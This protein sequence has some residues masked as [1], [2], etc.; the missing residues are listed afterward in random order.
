MKHCNYLN[1]FLCGV[2][3]FSALPATASVIINEVD[4][5]QPGADIAEFIELYNNGDSAISLDNYYIELINGFNNSVYNTISLTGYS[6]DSAGY[7]VVCN[8]ASLVTNCNYDTTQNSSWIQNGTPDAVALFDNI[9]LLD[10]LAY[11]GE[12]APYTENSPPLDEDNN[13]FI[14]SLS[15][16]PN[17]IDTNNNAL[18]FG[19]GCITPGSANIA[20]SGDCSTPSAVPLPA[21][22][23]LFG[24]GLVGLLG[25]ARRKNS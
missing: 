24:S 13:T 6:I 5:D 21:A 9:G 20:G 19:L 18:D 16:L 12:I 2:T 10:S 22:A 25:V 17:G 4:Y 3:L 15:R 23:W 7:F 14:A 8:D 1:S 11:E